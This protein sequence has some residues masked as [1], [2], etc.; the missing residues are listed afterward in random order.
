[1]RLHYRHNR[2]ES[3]TEG[4]PGLIVRCAVLLVIL[5]ICFFLSSCATTGSQPDE[6]WPTHVSGLVW[7]P[8]PQTARIG[9]LMSLS[10]HQD[11][12]I[13]KTWLRKVVDTFFGEEEMKGRLFRPYGVFARSGKIY[14]TDPGI[15]AIHVF[16]MTEKEYFMIKAVNGEN[17][18]S[19]I[20]VVADQDGE[21]YFSDSELKRI[22]VLNSSGKY[23][24]D[25]GSPALFA[26][27]AGI[28]LDEDRI[29]VVDTHKH[30]VFVFD[31]KDGKLLFSF[32]KNGSGKGDF[33]YPTNIFASNDHHIYITDSM[34]FRVQIFDRDGKF[35]ADFG[36]LGDASGDFSK[37]KG[38]A[39]DSEGHIYVADAD[40][41]VIQIF[42]ANGKLLLAFGKTGTGEGD[43]VLPAGVFIDGQ[44][45]IYVADSYNNRI[46][47]FQY[48]GG[49]EA[50]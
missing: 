43:L 34:N 46:Q 20:G 10:G 39:V 19:P 11:V 18:V 42:N 17:L 29:Y 37:P 41:D 26:R 5:N 28:A 2:A 48:L 1:M 7:P 44:D 47:I 8:P 23:L 40:F 35:I 38:I 25:V 31:K 13:K 33:N 21:F 45:R 50:K 49:R 32:G 15:P 22:F 6:E 9:Y 3:V 4:Y 16:D 30:C 24:R 27:P 14:V 36:K 12:R